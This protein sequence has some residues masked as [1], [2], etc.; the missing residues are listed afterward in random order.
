[1]LV[2]AGGAGDQEFNGKNICR[3]GLGELLTHTEVNP[4]NLATTFDKL[5]NSEIY[6]ET[7]RKF[8]DYSNFTDTMDTIAD[9][10]ERL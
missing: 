8:K 9:K 6:L 3:L 2:V 5:E 7:I 10:I 4:F 1:M